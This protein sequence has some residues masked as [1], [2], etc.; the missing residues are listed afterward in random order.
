MKW[1]SKMRYHKEKNSGKS[2]GKDAIKINK[3]TPS[4]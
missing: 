2:P 3:G 4:F 1:Y